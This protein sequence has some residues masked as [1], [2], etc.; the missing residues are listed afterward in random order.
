[1]RQ[2]D[3]GN[4]K[5]LI[6]KDVIGFVSQF[7]CM[8]A[9]LAGSSPRF[10]AIGMASRCWA[11]SRD[12]RCGSH[13]GPIPLLVQKVPPAWR[14]R[15]SGA[16]RRASHRI[17]L[18]RWHRARALRSV[19][20]ASAR[21]ATSPAPGKL[22]GII[23]YNRRFAKPADHVSPRQGAASFFGVACA[24]AER[25]PVAANGTLTFGR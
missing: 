14:L 10:W 4:A 18:V 7:F 11:C 9:Q 5:P 12:Q 22:L 8:G 21:G 1:V 16:W 24:R 3:A 17:W 15:I 20:N 19:M 23:S 13:A 25:G 2:R 6:A